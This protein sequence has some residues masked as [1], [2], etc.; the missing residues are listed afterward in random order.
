MLFYFLVTFIL[1]FRIVFSQLLRPDVLALGPYCPWIFNSC[2]YHQCQWRQVGP[3]VLKNFSV[4]ASPTWR[5]VRTV[6]LGTVF[7]SRAISVVPEQA[8]ITLDSGFHKVTTYT[9]ITDHQR[10]VSDHLT[11]VDSGDYP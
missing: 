8:P 5:L 10:L 6:Q 4:I 1:Y 7:Y 2:V 11:L 9:R 3:G